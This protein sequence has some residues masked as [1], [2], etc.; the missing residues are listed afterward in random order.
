MI[1]IS[2]LR[3]LRPAYFR[4]KLIEQRQRKI[5]DRRERK[6]Y[7]FMLD[8]TAGFLADL[9]LFAES[10]PLKQKRTFLQQTNALSTGK[11]T[12]ILQHKA[13][14]GAALYAL[15]F[16]ILLEDEDLVKS[17]RRYHTLLSAYVYKN[18]HELPINYQQVGNKRYGHSKVS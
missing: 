14:Y 2:A 4:E 5:A 17:V 16:V 12:R 18:Y 3:R 11:L 15:D 6:A 9:Y 7:R 13:C 1:T 8:E 10:L